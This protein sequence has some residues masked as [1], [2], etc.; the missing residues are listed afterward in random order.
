[1]NHLLFHNSLYVTFQAFTS[2]LGHVLTLKIVEMTS[3]F[4]MTV[5]DGPFVDSP[6]I[7]N[8]ALFDINN[9]PFANPLLITESNSI[10]IKVTHYNSW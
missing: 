2:E 3:D 6:Y 8:S 7:L 4:Y 9:M 10:N 5:K 1:M